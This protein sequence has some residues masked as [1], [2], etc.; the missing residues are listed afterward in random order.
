MVIYKGDKPFFF[1][2]AESVETLEGPHTSLC[3]NEKGFESLYG[4]N[5]NEV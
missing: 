3:I 4:C 1:F 2:F 5:G